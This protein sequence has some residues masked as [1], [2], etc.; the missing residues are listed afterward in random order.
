[1]AGSAI[2]RASAIMAS[3][4]VVSR[5][6]GIV[7]VIV[8]AY[9]IG[10]VG[11]K[12]GDAYA[13][14]NMLP[15]LLY[16][17][18]L[19]GM[20]TAVLVPQIVKAA[21]QK[22]GGAGYINKL[23]TLVTVAL[24]LITIVALFATPW[25]VTAFTLTWQ[26]EQRGLAI[27]FAYWCMPQILFFGIYAV[28]GEVLNAKSVFGP[29][30]WAP[31]LNNIVAI[32]GFGVFMLMFGADPQGQRTVGDWTSL[33]VA[34]LAGSATLGIASQAFILF[35]FWK[36][37][38]IRFRPDFKWRGMGLAETGRIAGWTLGALLITN[39]GALVTTNVLNEASGKGVSALALDTAWTIYIMP[40]SVITISIATAYFT[41]LAE[42][43]HAGNSVAF[44]RDFS[45]AVR[46]VMLILVLAAVIV[47]AVAPFVSR[48]VNLG[49]TLTQVDQFSLA[50]RA[51]LVSLPAFSFLFVVQRAFYATSDTRTP[52]FYACLRIAVTI[53]L[54]IVVL[55]VVPTPLVGTAVALVISISAV[56]E[57]I[58]ATLL[59]RRKLGGID[60][61]RIA[62]S[63]ARYLGAGALTLGVGLLGTSWARTLQPDF[64]PLYSILASMCIALVMAVA[65]LVVLLLL[66]SPELG[67][68]LSRVRMRVRR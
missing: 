60:G 55:N 56:I 38:G 67:F 61:R 47:F 13:N 32:V 19:G 44:T 22:D 25:I 5:L 27:A 8:L 62:A 28:L 37:A 46:Q 36:R 26:A 65:Y 30:T 53:T 45:A 21:K 42:W 29:S 68:V 48:V 23:V 1:M 50:L 6:L 15:N 54:S 51:Y 12:S 40:H 2:A 52:F 34:V 16:T 20:L 3:G 49:A 66:R 33:S 9:A 64:G 39:L 57:T 10:Q 14:G 35:A 41:R 59:L 58:V 18:L 4:T 11:S 7:K 63:L 17:V 24:T 43:H 31:V